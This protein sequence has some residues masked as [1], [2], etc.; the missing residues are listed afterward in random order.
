MD[1][2]IICINQVKSILVASLMI[3]S[4]GMADTIFY[5]ELNMKE[6]GVVG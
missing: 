6:I 4:M 5:L 2:G 3:K 1:G